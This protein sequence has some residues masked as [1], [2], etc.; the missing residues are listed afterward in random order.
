ML[1]SEPAQPVSE[2][3][4]L[5]KFSIESLCR[6][7]ECDECLGGLQASGEQLASE[8]FV[9]GITEAFATEW[10]P[11]TEDPA[12]CEAGIR[13]LIPLAIPA[14]IAGMDPAVGTTIC[15]NAI[16]GICA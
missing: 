11:T 13:I 2:M 15:N 8:D 9:A 3:Q 7:P 4:F 1:Q 6:S 16:P 5:D 10:C 14:L 12:R